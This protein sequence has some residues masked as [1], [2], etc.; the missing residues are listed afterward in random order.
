VEPENAGLVL[1]TSQL[2]RGRFR[3]RYFRNRIA[4][5]AVLFES[6]KAKYLIV[7]GNQA[8]GG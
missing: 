7:S 1:G 2:L 6:G 5:A 4:A 8:R 3:N